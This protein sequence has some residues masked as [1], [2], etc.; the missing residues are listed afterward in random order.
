VLPVN[1]P[2]GTKSGPARLSLRRLSRGRVGVAALALVGAHLAVLFLVLLVWLVGLA[3]VFRDLHWIPAV[4]ATVVFAVGMAVVFVKLIP[5]AHQ[6]E[7]VFSGGGVF[8]L[9]WLHWF[10]IVATGA[11]G[12]LMVALVWADLRWYHVASTPE[13]DGLRDQAMAMP[14]P[15]DW[16]LD[17]AGESNAAFPADVYGY[18]QSFDVP[19]AYEF[20]QMADWLSSPEWETSFGTLRDLQCD[21]SRSCQADVVP[22][23]AEEPVYVIVATYRRSELAGSTPTVDVDLQYRIT[24]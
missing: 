18:E 7:K 19:Q 16:S 21:D 1:T 13:I 10:A 3:P 24:E 4:L 6:Y 5:W 20:S 15:S 2:K 9:S 12:I 23:E 8:V 17:E 11:T 14:I 22:R